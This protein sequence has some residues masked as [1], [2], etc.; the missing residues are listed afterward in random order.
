MRDRWPHALARWAAYVL[1]AVLVLGQAGCLLVACG[2]A[3][4]AAA[5]YCY[6]QGKVCQTYH[7]DLLDSWMATRT[8]LAE[9]GMPVVTE[10]RD[11]SEGYLET[12]TADA[13]KVR[14][15]L[16]TFPGRVPADGLVTRVSVRVATFGDHLLSNRILDQVSQH[17]APADAVPPSTPPPL[18]P[19]GYAAPAPPANQ[20]A[21]P[22]LLPPESVPAPPK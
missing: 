16:E 19:A 2:V 9:L 13:D 11:G 21:P 8:A 15:Y 7:A 10:R 3:G 22:P 12:R 5:G 17:L 20:T 1:F 4:G 6:T 14:I 18:A